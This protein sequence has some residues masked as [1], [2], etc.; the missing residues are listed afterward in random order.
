EVPGGG[1]EGDERDAGPVALL[2][3]RTHEL[4]LRT[5]PVPRPEL[6]RPERLPHRDLNRV[7]PVLAG[8]LPRAPPLVV[9]EADDAPD[10]VQGA[11]P[12]PRP[13]RRGT[14]GSRPSSS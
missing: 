9:L 7:E 14:G 4:G 13:E 8:P 5:R 3:A 2:R 10:E 12:A 6:R 11:S 1:L